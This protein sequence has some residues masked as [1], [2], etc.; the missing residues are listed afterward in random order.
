MKTRQ[1]APAAGQGA[2]SPAAGNTWRLTGRMATPRGSF[3]A[4]LLVDGRV[5]GAGG[6]DAYG[7]FTLA[8]LYDPATGRWVHTG[9]MSSLRD[10]HVAARLNDGR[11]LVAGGFNGGGALASAELY[12][13]G[14]G[15]WITT[16]SMDTP[17]SFPIA[18]LLS[19][20]RMLVASGMGRAPDQL[21]AT[22]EIYNPTTTST[23]TPNGQWTPAGSLSTP[24]LEATLTPLPGGKAI[25]IGGFDGSGPL[26]SAEIYDPNPPPVGAWVPAPK[27]STRRFGHAATLLHDGRVFVAGGFDG[28][29]ALDSAEIYD[30]T[31]PAASAWVAAPPMKT[32][33][34]A[35]VGVTLNDGRVLVAGGDDPLGASATAQIYDLGP[36]WEPETL[37]V[38]AR[39]NATLTVLPGGDVLFAGGDTGNTDLT[40]GLASA[41]LFSP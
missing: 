33:R 10:L 27:M 20:G 30:P 31:A 17:R 21:I 1:L 5:L 29:A 4:T 15:A 3:T 2:P 38:G 9:R 23:F 37:P 32:P 14:T 35:P 34:D 18:T 11:V 16:V 40:D 28:S 19:D 12:D 26:D 8:E 22:A 39:R 13:P 6:S 25:A 7:V 36:G 24:R 41:E